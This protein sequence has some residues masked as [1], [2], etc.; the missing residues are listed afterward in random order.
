MTTEQHAG[1][2]RQFQ[3]KKEL[4][5]SGATTLINLHGL[6]GAKLAD[7]AEHASLSLKSVRYYFTRKDDLINAC[8][9]RAFEAYD[10]LIDH[11]AQ[12]RCATERVC[13]LI[14]AWMDLYA[15]IRRGQHPPILNF[16]HV[17][18]VDDRLD[19][20]VR[21]AY[22]RMFVRLEHLLLP[23]ESATQ[24]PHERQTT[25]IR[26]HFVLSQLLWAVVWIERYD[27]DHLGR[28]GE[29]MQRILRHGLL[30][31]GEPWSPIEIG[32]C[33][34][35]ADADPH[36]EA[37]LRAATT[38]INRHGYRGASVE[39]IAAELRKTK[40]AFYHRLDAKDSLVE[41]C[42]NRTFD[43][44]RSA[45]QMAEQASPRAA[46]RLATMTSA[47]TRF[48]LGPDGPLLRTSALAAVPLA[49]KE[50]MKLRLH[51]ITQRI[52]DT[53][54]DGILEGSVRPVDAWIAAQMI[55]GA[56][57][58]AAELKLWVPALSVEE[59]IECYMRPLFTNFLVD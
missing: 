47:L 36:Q 57:N 7:V 45:Q 24:S 32:I 48:Q 2:S 56:V 13:R 18:A 6:K 34:P 43:L 30:P 21:V 1:K 55:N 59:A 28:V 5:L 19:H 46:V 35:D 3:Q 54:T 20:P 33:A 16:G 50:D 39:K 37:F 29:H 14:D 15:R 52:Y 10:L 51:A 44:M 17:T 11:A 38:L 53:L 25:T 41:G 49:T 22:R 4:M 40:G 58:S 8:F 27:V 9:E 26:A 23:P 12:G 31:D 42:F